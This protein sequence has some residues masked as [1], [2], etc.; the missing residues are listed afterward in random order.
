[1]NDHM[2]DIM[3]NIKLNK[4]KHYSDDL[5]SMFEKKEEVPTDDEIT[6][7]MSPINDLETK[8][9]K[10]Y[11]KRR[12]EIIIIHDIDECSNATKEAQIELKNIV[13]SSL[14]LDAVTKDKYISKVISFPDEVNRNRNENYRVSGYTDY[15]LIPEQQL[16][17]VA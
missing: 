11:I 12:S 10:T 16:K 6:R 5:D 9:V 2:D 1:M 3:L 4:I 8:F 13:E 14:D 17:K 15:Y 7:L